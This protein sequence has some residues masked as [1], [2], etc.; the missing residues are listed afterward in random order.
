M[1]AIQK[2]PAGTSLRAS[3]IS[4]HMRFL[5]A[6]IALLVVA[7]LTGCAPAATDPVAAEDAVGPPIP[8]AETVLYEL[9]VRSFTEEGTFEAIIP[10][11]AGL[12]E[13]GVT[14]IWLMPIHPVGEI[15]RKGTLGSPYSIVDYRAINP[16]FGDMDIFR[17]LL[18][19]VHDHDMTLIL[20]LVANHTAWD[21]AWVTEHPEWY[22]RGDD[23][24]ITHPP[25]TDWVDVAQL[26]FDN[27]DLRAA[28]RAEMRFWVEEVGIDGYRADVAELVP[29]DFWEEAIAEL[30]SIRPVLMLAE[31]HDVRLHGVGFDLTYSW[32]SYHGLK[33]VWQGGS[34]DSLLALIERELEVYPENARLRFTTN[35][36]ETAWDDTPIALFDGPDGARAAAVIAMTLP[37]VP[38]I[39]NGQEVGDT[40]RL[41]LFER[42]PIQWDADPE[43]RVFYREL[44]DRRAASRALRE[45]TF[46]S[47]DHDHSDDVVAFR[48]VAGDESVTVV[49]NVRPEPREVDLPIHGPLSLDAYEWLLIEAQ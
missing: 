17:R 28:M 32:D 36:D 47:I 26:D 3:S 39:Y 42:V 41:P 13:L 19:A 44:L 10:R 38:L 46:Q 9:Y 18:A 1:E 40:Q 30:R 15:E 4:E 16:E 8:L 31:G 11:L 12:R 35:H 48:R 33:S 21:H 29:D 2:I 25:G 5:F 7:P 6:L 49:V 34:A 14:T 37:G 20:D 27:Y 45:G 43:L 23:G 22:V 24:E